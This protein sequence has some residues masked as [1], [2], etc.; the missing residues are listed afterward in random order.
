MT[1]WFIAFVLLVSS[2][3]TS[4]A[5]TQAPRPT[6][7]VV[8]APPKVDEKKVAE[9][10]AKQVYIAEQI[11]VDIN[12]LKLPE[13]RSHV[14]A[15]VGGLLWK[16]DQ[17]TSKDLFQ[18]SINELL[19]VQT[20]AE[21]DEKNRQN[22]NDLR[23]IQSIR[24]N[25]L[26]TIGMFDAEFALESLY[27]TRTGSI[28]RALAQAAEPPGTRIAETNGNTSLVANTELMLEQRLVRMAAEQ[29]P[30][31][32]AKFLQDS[33]KK[34]LSNETLSLLK[35]LYEK[36]PELADSLAAETLDKLLGS[37]FSTDQSDQRSIALSTTILNDSLRVRKPGAKELKFEEATL[38]SLANKLINYSISAGQ[39]V[40]YSGI[41][42]ANLIKF[43]EKYSPA[44]VAALKKLEKANLPP[45]T[46]GMIPDADSR[47][48]MESQM[49]PAQL[50]A[51]AKKLPAESRTPVYQNAAMRMARA[52]DFNAAMELL[53]ANFSG[54]ALENAINGLNWAYAESLINQGK[55][56]EAE[57]M[58]DEMPDN[59]RR[60]LLISLATRAFAKDAN[61]NKAYSISVLRKVRGTLPDRPVDQTEL[62]QF[63]Q[64][65]NAYAPID[66]DDAFGTFE[67]VIP[68]LI[69]LA[70]ANAIVQGFQGQF[71]V[72]SGEFIIANGG[73]YGFQLDP[74]LIR[75]LAKADFDR[76]IKL[77]DGFTRR[78]MRISIKMQL[79]ETGLN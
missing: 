15:K 17:K 30:E 65:T 2:V 75:S 49:P 47:K 69:E 32:A 41:S 31:R 43:A 48:L 67:P 45:G 60:A 53:N 62:Q 9:R 3:V 70:D 71:S 46:A 55:Y 57:R 16:S 34:G 58:I 52:G 63:I 77:I 44:M 73:Q 1:R 37:T 72:R 59:N 40:R 4:S 6:L 79:A 10:L 21:T 68:I 29:N 51:E 42:V 54:R 33:I 13:N 14:Y 23:T 7:P 56:T 12:G 8:Q 26:T 39:N 64:L 27:R 35:K 28:Q 50:V 36:D 25:I 78:E 11:L 24:P 66:P 5:Q 61:E 74:N 76:T 19:N 22:G 38:R 18:R 20:L